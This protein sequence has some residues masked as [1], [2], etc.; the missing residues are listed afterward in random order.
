MRTRQ[1]RMLV[2]LWLLPALAPAQALRLAPT[3]PP[4]GTIVVDVASNHAAINMT[5]T[6]TGEVTSH[7]V[8]PSKRVTIP[9]PA[10]LPPGTVLTLS[11]GHGLNGHRAVIEIAPP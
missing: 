11:V 2:V 6:S 8:P 5:N 1:R 7:P 3:T 4:S 10:G 9:V